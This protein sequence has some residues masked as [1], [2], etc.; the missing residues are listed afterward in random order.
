MDSRKTISSTVQVEDGLLLFIVPS[1]GA[2]LHQA[3]WKYSRAFVLFSAHCY[4]LLE[5]VVD[6]I[7]TSCGT[8]GGERGAAYFI[9]VKLVSFS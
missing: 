7:N 9:Q 8:G 5:G 1:Y 3:T 4:Q 6:E 2:V